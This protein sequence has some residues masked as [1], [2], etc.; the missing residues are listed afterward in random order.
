MARIRDAR[1]L[2][3]R[4]KG[5]DGI[6]SDSFYFEMLVKLSIKSS[7]VNLSNIR[8]RVRIDASLEI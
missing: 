5:N 7:L 1:Y 6:P 2:V 8:T 4:R 3:G